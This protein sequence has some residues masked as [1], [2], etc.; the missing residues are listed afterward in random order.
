MYEFMHKTPEE[1]VRVNDEHITNVVTE[2]V[3]GHEEVCV[4]FFVHC[5]I[6]NIITGG[7]RKSKKSKTRS[8]L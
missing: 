6:T 1:R 7:D 2:Y 3:E 4:Y 8:S 5:L